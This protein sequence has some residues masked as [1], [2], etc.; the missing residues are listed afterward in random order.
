MGA[1]DFRCKGDLCDTAHSA[2]DLGGEFI[3]IE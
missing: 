3:A 2:G 1:E